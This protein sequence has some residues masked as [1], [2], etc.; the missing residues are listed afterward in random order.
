MELIFEKSRPGRSATSIPES[1]V[2]RVFPGN[3]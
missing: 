3:A 2:P 1:D